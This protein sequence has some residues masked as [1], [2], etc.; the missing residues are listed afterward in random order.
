STALIAWGSCWLASRAKA[1]ARISRCAL[2]PLLAS[3]VS[4]GTDPRGRCRLLRWRLRATSSGR[5]PWSAGRTS[6]ATGRRH[7]RLTREVP[8]EQAGDASSG[9]EAPPR[10]LQVSVD[11]VTTGK[12]NASRLNQAGRRVMSHSEALSRLTIGDSRSEMFKWALRKGI[13]QFERDGT[14][15]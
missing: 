12:R 14:T 13:D 6:S 10:D 3:R 5:C 15:M 9:I 8:N 1:G 11:K 4:S 7:P 2:R